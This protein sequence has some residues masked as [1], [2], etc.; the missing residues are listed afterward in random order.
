ML[1]FLKRNAFAFVIVV[2]VVVAGHVFLT[3]DAEALCSNEAT[4]YAEC[5]DRK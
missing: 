1:D 5:S 4:A 2:S 3:K